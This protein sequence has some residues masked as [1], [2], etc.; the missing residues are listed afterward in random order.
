MVTEVINDPC[1]YCR[2]SSA[3]KCNVTC[4]VLTSITSLLSAQEF[5]TANFGELCTRMHFCNYS[6]Y[7]RPHQMQVCA[8]LTLR[9]GLCCH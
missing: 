6:I 9:L 7:I 1:S 4:Y 8:R 2:S 5:P 3:S